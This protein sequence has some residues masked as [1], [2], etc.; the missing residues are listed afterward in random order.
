MVDINNDKPAFEEIDLTG[1]INQET[2]DFIKTDI[3]K[4]LGWV[5]TLPLK[6]Q[7]KEQLMLSIL[8][9][10]SQETTGKG[11]TEE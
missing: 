6:D 8:V 4:L 9:T 1:L 10:R 2:P 5:I 3:T 7:V 11:N